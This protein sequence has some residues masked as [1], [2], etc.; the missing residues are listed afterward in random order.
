MDDHSSDE[1]SRRGRVQTTFR[2]IMPSKKAGALE[3][4]NGFGSGHELDGLSG[5]L[6]GS[7]LVLGHRLLALLSVEVLVV[8][9]LE[10]HRLGVVEK[11]HA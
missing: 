3:P 6:G 7:V 4:N 2:L 10:V 8:V 1:S 9:S 11:V 5:I